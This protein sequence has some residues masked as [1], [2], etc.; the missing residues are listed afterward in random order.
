MAPLR[1]LKRLPAPHASQ[2]RTRMLL[3]GTHADS[4]H[5]RQCS[6]SDDHLKSAMHRSPHK[7]KSR[8]ER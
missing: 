5:V 7:S 8:K 4:F 3:E 1:Y 2:Y 6:T